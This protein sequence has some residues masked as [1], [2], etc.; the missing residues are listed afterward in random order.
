M[1]GYLVRD[2]KAVPVFISD[3]DGNPVTVGGGSGGGVVT[4]PTASSLNAQVVGNVASGATDAGNPVKIAGVYN[5]TLPAYTTG[6]R[7]DLQ[8]NPAGA[9]QVAATVQGT[10]SDNQSLG[11]YGS[12]MRRDATGGL[13]LGVYPFVFDG[14][15]AQRQRGDT[16]GTYMV[17]KGSGT[18]ATA[19]VSVG[20]TST[21]VVAARAGRGSVKIT[22]L[23]TTDVFI[24]VTGV[25]TTTGDIL[26]GTK[27]ASIT[28]PTNAA[29][30]AVAA[31]AQTVSVMEVF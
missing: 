12:L 19:Q 23:G 11:S 22:N 17:S 5:S 18:I 9:L 27:G 16:N 31:T 10:W 20:T 13:N 6:Q 21:Q 28:I 3:D 30:F 29:V 26:P 25:T 8:L 7:G 4:Q 1:P 15:N 14:T 2:T 24:G